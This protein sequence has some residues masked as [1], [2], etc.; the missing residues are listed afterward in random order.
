MIF[1]YFTEPEHDPKMIPQTIK[2]TMIFVG[3][4]L[5]CIMDCYL[6]GMRMR[7]HN[8][9]QKGPRFKNIRPPEPH[10]AQGV[11][12]IWSHNIP[13]CYDFVHECP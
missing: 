12:A 3:T 11:N 10:S 1:S 8:F 13:K 6:D 5:G 4:Y 2:N 7:L 9:F